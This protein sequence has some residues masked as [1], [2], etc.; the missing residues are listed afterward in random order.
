MINSKTYDVAS[1]GILVLDVFGKSIEDFPVPGTS[2]FFDS[3]EV[4]PGGCAYNTGVDMARLGLKVSV[5]GLVGNDA[6]GRL[7]LDYLEQEKVDVSCVKKTNN[8]GTSFSFVMIPENGQRRIYTSFGANGILSKQDVELERIRN[9]RLFHIGGACMLSALDGIPEKELFEYAQ[10]NGVLT[11]M[12]PVNRAESAPLLVQCLPYLDYFFPNTEESVFITGLNDPLDQ[13]HYYI[14]KG[15]KTAGIKTGGTGSL[16]SDGKTIWKS[17][18]Y[19]VPVA[20]TCGAGDAFVAGFLYSA[21]QGWS[22]PESAKFASAVASLCVSA[23]GTTS[24][25]PSAN[26]VTEFMKSQSLPVEVLKY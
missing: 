24:A 9:S 3:M 25:I 19:N 7:L 12:D 11:C 17:G 23:I 2:V 18:I 8:S 21:L 6:F 14:D 22:A 1:L 26:K 20:D 5:M 10:A 4:H 15:V 13:L 16:V